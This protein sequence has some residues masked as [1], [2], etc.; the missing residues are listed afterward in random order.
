MNDDSV[1][2][3][4]ID[5]KCENCGNNLKFSPNDGCLKCEKCGSEKKVTFSEN[6]VKL[7]YDDVD[8]EALGEWQDKNKYIKC[9]N[10]GSSIELKNNEISINCPYCDSQNIVLEKDIKGLYPNMIVRFAFDKIQ[11]G[12]NFQKQVK[13]KFMAPRSFKKL[14]PENKIEGFY[15][16]AFSFDADTSSTY[17]GV[18]YRYEHRG[19]G[20]DSQTVRV[21]FKIDGNLEFKHRDVLVESSARL[22]Q[23]DLKSLLP[24]DFSQKA[25]FY[26][27][28]LLGYK[29]EQYNEPF[30]KVVSKSA[31]ICKEQIRNAI[32]KKYTYDGVD[33]LDVQSIYKNKCYAYCMMPV[34]TFEFNYKDKKYVAYMNGQT[35]KVGSGLPVSKVK[36]A[37]GIILSVLIVLIPIL[38][39]VFLGE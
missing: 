20:K 30:K 39:L 15:F 21:S 7:P 6:N 19:I 13:K 4:T 32:L 25:D 16:P 26:P 22:T 31:E 23:L 17:K 9:K 38:L 1:K 33:K 10:C 2:L 29:V 3:E 11:A 28:Y 35:G 34:Y 37:C 8:D 24:F 5:G 14:L 36:V 12:I 18:L 27:E